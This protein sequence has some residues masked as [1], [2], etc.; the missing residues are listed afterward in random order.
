[1][2]TSGLQPRIHLRLRIGP[3]GVTTA[4]CAACT[5][6]GRV[7][8]SR[9]LG[10]VYALHNDRII[11]HGTANESL[12]TREGRRGTLTDHIDLFAVVF[13]QPTVVM[14]VMD[15]FQSF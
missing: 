13:F 6:D 11:P 15:C 2:H 12:L 10:T 4:H 9:S 8:R 3:L 1:M 5:M 7:E 14:V